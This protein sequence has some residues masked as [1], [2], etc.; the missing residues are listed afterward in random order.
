M[1]DKL[2]YLYRFYKPDIKNIEDL[3]RSRIFLNKPEKFNDPFEGAVK[4]E[5]NIYIRMIQRSYHNN[6]KG[7][8]LSKF[9]QFQFA[10]FRNGNSQVNDI[11]NDLRPIWVADLGNN[12]AIDLCNSIL[13][14]Y[15]VMHSDEFRIGCFSGFKT[16]Y[17]FYNRTDMWAYYAEN[18]S[19][20][21]VKYSTKNI[22]QEI[23]NKIVNIRYDIGMNDLPKENQ[24]NYNNYRYKSYMFKTKAWEHEK[25]YR[26]ILE[27]DECDRDSKIKFD[28]VDTIFIG[29]N[30]KND[31]KES[32]IDIAKEKKC[33]CK[34]I[35]LS[36]NRRLLTS[37]NL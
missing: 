34:K 29:F 8:D 24:I 10:D 2:K 25:E 18:G 32:L 33:K 15:N 7:W 6:N 9:F 3:K 23:K 14:V 35:S 26:L 11:I 20:F 1:D 27:K 31:L 16:S 12:G 13:R 19:G 36:E 30:A 17:E 4:N 37:A 5:S 21:C 22:N 28:Y